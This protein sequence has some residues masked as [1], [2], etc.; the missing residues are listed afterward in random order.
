MRHAETHLVVVGP[1]LIEVTA[2][3]WHQR[4]RVLAMFSLTAAILVLKGSISTTLVSCFSSLWLCNSPAGQSA[5]QWEGWRRQSAVLISGSLSLRRKEG[6]KWDI[7]KHMHA[8]TYINNIYSYK[9]TVTIRRY[10]F[11]IY[12]CFYNSNQM[13]PISLTHDKKW[14]SC[15]GDVLATLPKLQFDLCTGTCEWIFMSGAELQW[16]LDS[17]SSHSFQRGPLK[18]TKL[19]LL[20]AHTV[21]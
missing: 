3:I 9:V 14:L 7:L 15:V 8:R 16:V 12:V 11:S 2:G 5:P 18:N 10:I 19:S 4:A 21:I 20:K 17:A 13:A 6:N 1:V